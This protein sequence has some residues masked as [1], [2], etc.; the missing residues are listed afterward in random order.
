MGFAV[1]RWLLPWISVFAVVL[2][3][4]RGRAEGPI[5]YS[6][7][8]ES[9]AGTEVGNVARDLGVD[10][11]DLVGRKFRLN[12]K[13]KVQYFT[14]SMKSGAL[15]TKE[16]LDREALCG[17]IAVCVMNLEVVM[18]NPLEFH[19]LEVEIVDINDNA[20]NFPSTESNFAISESTVP[21]T[22]FPLKRASDPDVGPNS[23]CSYSLSP[24]HFFTL[25]T[26]LGK[27]K[28]ASVELV[29]TNSVDREQQTVHE[30]T[31]TAEDD[32]N[33]KK[34]GTQ[35]IIVYVQ[36]VNDNAPVF[37]KDVYSLNVLENI[38]L[39]NLLI[40]VNAT[41]PDVG[42]NG[43]VVYSLS[44]P[45]FPDHERLFSIDADNGEIRIRGHL[46]FED[47][48]LYE[49]NVQA[50][51]NGSPSMAR[52][53]K[54]L[55]E[56][57][58]ANDNAP[59]VEVTSFSSPVKEDAQ[60]G[61]VIALFTVTD[62]DSGVNGEVRCQ[63]PSV[64]PFTLE[65]KYKNFYS[66]SVK[67]PLD[68]EVA[69][70]YNVTVVATDGGSPSLSTLKT[71]TVSV[72][73]VNDNPPSFTELS[74]VTS[75]PENNVPGSHV[76]QVSALD[77]DTGDNARVRYSLIE[78]S[79]DAASILGLF[80]IH[81]ETG[82][83]SALQSFDYEKLQVVQFRV[84][85][86]DYGSPSLSGMSNVTVFIQDANDNPPTIFHTV[87]GTGNS[88]NTLQV[89]QA[90]NTGY[91][92]TKIR[93]IDSDSGHNAWLN[94]EFKEL[95][96]GTPFRIGRYT[97][98]ISLRHPL[99]ESYMERYELIVL[100]KDNGTPPL[101]ATLTLTVSL[102][103]KN[104][105]VNSNYK[106]IKQDKNYPNNLNSYLII[107]IAFILGIFI[108]CIILFTVLHYL[109]VQNKKE[110]AEKLDFCHD[111]A[112]KFS[113]SQSQQYNLYLTAQ[114]TESGHETLRSNLSNQGWTHLIVSG[115]MTRDLMQ[116]YS[117]T[118]GNASQTPNE[119]PKHPNPD[120]RYSAS[121]RAGVQSSVHMEESA[122]LRG[123]P[124]GLE[125]Q[126]PTVSSATT[127]PEGGGE[128]SPPVGAGVNS[129]SWTFKYGPGN[130]KQPAPV[131]PPDFP[132][133]FIIPGSPAIISIRQDQPPSQ[134]AEKGNFITF[135]K[136]EE[137]KKKKKK[138]KGTTKTTDK[139]EKGNS[140]T[141][142]SDQ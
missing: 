136:K 15:L 138:K 27:L 80:S 30:L 100:V 9:E 50:Q 82:A 95:T 108:V 99:G 58:D 65:S 57:I 8:E 45:E 139:K 93:A 54:V 129:N 44:N 7:L 76:L 16:I 118:E 122:V 111:E 34:S 32:G 140:T 83:I 70:E 101:S 86:K 133:N 84:K 40:K 33:P 69:S 26:K 35:I 113:Y 55:L 52:H 42:S 49:I 39:G 21:G 97:G 89:P 120:W 121:L 18:D 94:Y 43:E 6:V 25:G 134:T 56:I 74:Y 66:L 96:T 75:V 10:V 127:E 29:L 90:A 107:S 61:L 81:P 109:K 67:E 68:R 126:W 110:M 22:H 64:L 17:S 135:G 128:V 91:V 72:S 36:D 105:E 28:S 141:D 130:P 2:L 77:P 132:D 14:V 125:Q 1:R 88:A 37:E 123:V 48:H 124:A 112:G 5:R 114:P 4:C 51:D 102:L 38:P 119:Q 12:Y 73:D 142:N 60:P 71:I 79:V 3:C 13:T 104:P 87:S 11:R 103:E 63:I 24:S 115:G 47:S 98:E 116:R 106:H 41:D 19:R 59:E 53:C 131:I 62:K 78:N 20:P 137:T 117:I 92:V 85:A 23:Q 46:D 31:L